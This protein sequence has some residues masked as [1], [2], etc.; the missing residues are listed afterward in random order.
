M[1]VF[2]IPIW[3]VFSLLSGVVLPLLVGLVTT[4][5]T[6]PGRRAVILAAL[7]LAL[8]LATELGAA[9]QAGETYNLGA[10]LLL[11]LGTFL[12]AV[13]THY[14]FWKPTGVTTKVQD[15]L[16]KAGADRVPGP[17]HLA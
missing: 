2:D 4:R 16:V 3:Q 12:I 15:T 17:D 8:N 9:L 14:G 6:H 1:I 5:V 11:G 7:A 13:G 10:A